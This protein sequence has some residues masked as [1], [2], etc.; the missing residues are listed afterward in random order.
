MHPF[1]LYTALVLCATACTATTFGVTYNPSI[2]NISPPEKVASTLH[3]LHIQAV[4]LLYPTPAALRAFANTNISLLL[5]VPNYLVSYFAASGSAAT[6]WLYSHVLPFHPG[7]RI[8][9]ISV[10]SD[11]IA[12]TAN[13]YAASGPTTT[14][15]TAMK[16]LHFALRDLGIHSIPVSTTLSFINVMTT[17]FPPSS[18]EFQVPD[19]SLIITPLLQ[20]LNETNS[21]LLINLYPYITYRMGSEIALGTLCSKNIRL[22][23]WMTPSP[24]STT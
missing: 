24:V 23:S 7:T 3:R 6:T 18:K 13:F 20:F 2:P 11:V 4:H 10:G 14:L 9:L 16:N 8:S 19:N 21:S 12:A 22:I 15:V 5:S 1:I 17:S